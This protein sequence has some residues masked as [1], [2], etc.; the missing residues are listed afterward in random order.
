MLNITLSSRLVALGAALAGLAGSALG[1]PEPFDP[2]KERNWNFLNLGQFPGTFVKLEGGQVFI[3]MSDGVVRQFN[4][5]QAEAISG[6]F[7]QRSVAKIPANPSS[8]ALG[9]GDGPLI[10]LSAQELAA[11]P[12]KA[13]P[14]KGRLG[15][16]FQAMNQAPKVAEVDGRKAVVF[17]HAPWLLPFDYQTMVSDFYMPKEAIGGQ[18]I[19]VVAWLRNTGAPI[20]RETFF[21]WS[22]KDSGELDGPD[23]SYGAYEAMQWYS[24]KMAFPRARFPKLN[25]WQQLAFVMTPNASRCELKLF[26]NGEMVATKLVNKPAEKLLGSNL[27]FLG[28]AWEAWWGGS[29]ATRPAR[30]FTGALS[31]L[32]MFGRALS[33]EEIRKLDGNDAAFA[34]EPA[35]I[36][37]TANPA[38]KLSWT[39][40]AAGAS[41]KVYFGTEKD[42][43]AKRDAKVLRTP[44][45]IQA[46]TFDPGALVAGQTYYWRVD[47]QGGKSQSAVW[48]FTVASGGAAQPFPADKA[49]HVPTSHERLAWVPNPEATAQVIHFGKDRDAVLGGRA[50]SAKLRNDADEA[51]IPVDLKLEKLEPNTTYY[52]RVEQVGA[53]GAVPE[54]TLWSF[55]TTKYELAFDGAVSEPFPKVIPQDGFYD[56]LMDLDGYPIISPPGNHDLHIRASRHALFKLFDGRPDLVRTLQGSNTA[57]HLASRQH[58]GWGWSPFVCSSYG[59]G[60]A[61]LREGAILLHETGHQFH[62]QGAEMLDPTFRYRLGEAF[63]TGRREG[64]WA[65]DYGGNNMWECVAVCASWWVNDMAQDE[66]DM[67]TREVLRLNDPRVYAML[68][69]YWPGDTMVELDPAGRVELAADG[70]LQALGNLGGIEYFRPNGGWRFY[71]R[72]V[73]KFA[74]ASGAPRIVTVGGAA[75]LGMAAGDTLVWNKTTW[76]SLDGAR[77]WAV[78]GWF[79]QA[80]PLSGEQTLVSWGPKGE[81]GMELKWAGGKGGAPGWHH[82]AWN[83][84]GSELQVYV[85]GVMEKSTAQKLALAKGVPITIGGTFTGA[86]G[87]LRIYNNDL[88]PAKIAELHQRDRSAYPGD[89]LEVAGRLAV[90]VDARRLAPPHD[91]K[92]EV[93]FPTELNKPWLRSWV[94][95]G[96]L[97]GKLVNEGSEAQTSQPLA[98]VAHGVEAVTFNGNSRMIS[99]FQGRGLAGGT[100]EAW[101]Y[102]EKGSE[103]ATVMQWGP[104]GLPASVIPVDGWHHVVVAFDKDATR[105]YIDGKEK[106]APAVAGAPGA[107]DYL[108]V[109]AGAGVPL[110]N[111]LRGAIA[112][113]RVHEGVLD[114][115]KVA[116]NFSLSNLVKPMVP[117]PAPAATV[118]AERQ[119]QLSWQAGI[120]SATADVYLGTEAAAVASADRQSPL[121]LGAKKPGE[122]RPNLRPGTRYFWRVDALDK[123]GKVLAKGDVWDFQVAGGMLVKLDAAALGAGPVKQWPNTGGAGGVF[124]SASE[125]DTWQ[126]EVVSKLGV[127]GVDFSGRKALLSSF[128]APAELLGGAPFTVVVRAYC[129]DTRGLEREQTMFSW[130]RRPQGRAEF[131]WGTH[132]QKGAFAGGPGIEFGYKGPFAET[133]RMK[134]NAPVLDGWRHIAYTYDPAKKQLGIYV[135]GVLNRME[136]VELKIPAGELICLG[137]LRSGKGAD[138]PF[139][140][141]IT[142][143]AIAP[144]ALNAEQIAHLAKGSDL[145]PQVGWLVQ[146]DATSLPEGKLA[147]WPNKGK[148]GGQFGLAEE[149]LEDPKVEEVAGRKAV[150]FNGRN[151]FMR[152]S[153]VTPESLT[154]NAPL[155]VEAW[156][157]NPGCTDAETIFS[158]APQVAMKGYLHDSVNRAANF[159]YG[160]AKDSERDSRP[161]LFNTGASS[162]N[163]GWKTEAPETNKWVHLAWVY[164]G[165]YRGTFKVY[166]NGRVVAERGFYALDTLGG[167][168]MHL[169]AAWNTARGTMSQFSGSLAS[170]QVYDYARTPEEITAAA[171]G[172]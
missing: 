46:T 28:C 29:W 132:P 83:Y 146:L 24:E 5:G 125:R 12:L 151:T 143:L 153:G 110:N 131:C 36:S 27:A 62:M 122:L 93:F 161:A 103:K 49:T 113:L 4:A 139:A 97:G 145:P 135:D 144:H 13:W 54:A 9:T 53:P 75:A 22:A 1:A 26:V 169:G 51:F 39:A 82:V 155:T 107:D 45:P 116:R 11:G 71:E 119:P 86:L 61:V 104:W 156:V 158:L 67:R 154:G 60:E 171:A 7:L 159:N 80:G 10:S 106:P 163:I 115:T 127:K 109:G 15:G 40:G 79:Y 81:G 148:L 123:S 57:T 55:T 130:G 105:V 172:K 100:L 99:N 98:G 59:E 164:S 162:R 118:V 21:T 41:Y 73:G 17:E 141:L 85:D 124:A 23:F 102:V 70:A 114:A 108:V 42:L 74:V 72:S 96:A 63:N 137:G 69:E 157:Y 56:R 20:D 35:H 149:A 87:H 168:P 160:N 94:N 58:R 134:H 76:D 38:S 147:A 65:G 6:S 3:K 34:P 18:P 84:T 91:K 43:V 101:V 16:S 33:Q 140:G 166:L 129:S 2:A 142:E 170:L 112:W 64:L 117:S 89:A 128:Q 68:A 19:T 126:P 50:A 47:Q 88:H 152:S 111:G 133:D 77:P 136:T 121:F 95:R 92:T 32:Q 167:G 44:A 8:P 14:N 120:A 25:E 165:G 150:T 30:P 31:G 66:G 37:H 138:N 52:W 90:S 78:E 48:S